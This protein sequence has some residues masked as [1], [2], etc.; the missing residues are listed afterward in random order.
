MHCAIVR[1]MLYSVLLTVV[2]IGVTGASEWRG[3]KGESGTGFSDT[4]RSIYRTSAIAGSHPH[5]DEFEAGPTPEQAL[6]ALRGGIEV[7]AVTEAGRKEPVCSPLAVWLCLVLLNTSANHHFTCVVACIIIDAMA[8]RLL[9][10]VVKLLLV[11][12]MGLA[13][14]S[15][16]SLRCSDS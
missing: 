6:H 16:Q 5:P 8:V 1:L 10:S 9:D 2:V 11:L 12:P 14:V 13:F 4:A 3:G 7:I 15:R